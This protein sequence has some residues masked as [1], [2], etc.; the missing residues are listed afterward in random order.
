MR[1]ERHR[2]L[3]QLLLDYSVEVKPGETL[4][5]E[6]KGKETLELAKQVLKLATERGVTPFW[7]YSDESLLR[8]FL[9][10]AGE[11]QMKRMAEL[12]MEIM[13]R[14]NAYIGLRGSDNPFDLADIPPEQ[15]ERFNRL[16]YHPVHLEQ[17]V[18]KTRWVVLRYPN[19]AM[20][21]LAQTSQEAFEDFYFSVCLLDY[22]RLSQAEEKLFQ[23]MMATDQVHILGPGTDLRFSIKGIKCRKCDGHRNIPD[24]E[25][26][27]APVRDS[28]EGYITFNTPTLNQG[29]VFENVHLEFQKGKIVKAE[30]GPNTA[31]LNRILDT[32]EGARY[33]GEFSLGVNPFIL[34]PMKDTLFDEKIAGS[35]H[36]TPGQAYEEADNGNR[37]A[38]H[39]DMVLIQRPEYGGGE[40][41]F[42]G[43]LVRKDGKFTDPELEHL[44]S[45]DYLKGA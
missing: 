44:F 7:F 23:L 22:Q 29:T 3:A 2:Q 42:D 15:M 45:A 6:V 5:L 27:T 43:K 12:H 35:L 25:V 37:S 18:K 31:K 8:Q 41:W 36:F 38:I 30:A 14:T 20:A 26:F 1:D 9:R 21:Q 4:Y 39:W 32:D 10:G 19:N 33:I 17:R 28:V 11:D 13:R 16:F 40:I 34:H 24:G